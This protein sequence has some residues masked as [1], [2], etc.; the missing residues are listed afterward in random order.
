[1]PEERKRVMH[2]SNADNVYLHRDFHG[3]LSV[4][5]DYVERRFGRPAVGDFLRQFARAYYA[6]LSERIR[7]DGLVAVEEYL[8]RIYE[9]EGGSVVCERS[10]DELVVQV[11]A[12]PAVTHMRRRGYPVAESF[13]ETIR[14]V[15]A[16]ICEA[17]P[18]GFALIDYDPISGR[19]TL[20]FFRIPAQ[21][22][23]A[24]E[25]NP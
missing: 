15:N 10:E 21:S 24:G 22:A 4:A 7:H 13:V 16:A 25:P 14:V 23:S 8:R 19:C 2:R 18:F 11:E 12:C 3:A 5:L 9:A 6:P 17:T 1:M 20:R